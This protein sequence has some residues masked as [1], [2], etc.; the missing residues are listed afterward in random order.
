M[1]LYRECSNYYR[2]EFSLK[3][4]GFNDVEWKEGWRRL[5]AAYGWCVEQ[6]GSESSGEGL[7][8]CEQGIATIYLRRPEDAFAFRMR[9]C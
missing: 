4:V 3:A 6:F 7:W 9:W 2:F 5:D 1:F 8:Y